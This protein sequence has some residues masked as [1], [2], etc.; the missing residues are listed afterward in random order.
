MHKNKSKGIGLLKSING[1]LKESN[2]FLLIENIPTI[3]TKDSAQ[4]YTY[5]CQENTNNYHNSC[6]CFIKILK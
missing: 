1:V 4:I 3:P 5:A 6:Q 2:L